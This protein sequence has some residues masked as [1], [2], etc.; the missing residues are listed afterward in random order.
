MY[1]TNKKLCLIASV[2]TVLKLT[3]SS[4]MVT[5]LKS[6]KPHFCGNKKFCL[7]TTVSKFTA[8]P[9]S[10]RRQFENSQSDKMTTVLCLQ[11][12]LSY[13]NSMERFTAMPDD[14]SLLLKTSVSWCPDNRT[15]V[16]TRT[17][18]SWRH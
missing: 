14:H 3:R 11:E 8:D 15:I 5:V 12:I 10:S 16:L 6:G 4:L 7:M 17:S 18:A 2:K 9:N 13:D 1:C